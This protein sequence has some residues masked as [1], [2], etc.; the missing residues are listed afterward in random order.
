MVFCI[1]VTILFALAYV[2]SL[3]VLSSTLVTAGMQISL[4]GFFIKET[5]AF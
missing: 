4:F 2:L 5:L 3:G 1:L